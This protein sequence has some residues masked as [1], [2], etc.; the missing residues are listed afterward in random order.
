MSKRY[1]LTHRAQI[2]LTE[3]LEFIAQRSPH[4]AARV[5]EEFQA[6]MQQLG[7][8]PGMGHRREDVTDLPV[9]F[10]SVHSYLIVYRDDCRPIDIV[11]I[12]H[13]ARNLKAILKEP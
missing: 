6:A 13:G 5:G 7:Q 10:W 9:R 4:N 11:H 3:I 2:E 12:V 1:R 8:M